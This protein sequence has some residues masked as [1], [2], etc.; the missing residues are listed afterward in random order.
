MSDLTSMSDPAWHTLNRQV[1]VKY[2][3]LI[4][5]PEGPAPSAPTMI[6][7]E[8]L[9]HD[10]ARKDAH[11][12]ADTAANRD[13]AG[14]AGGECECDCDGVD[15]GGDSDCNSEEDAEGS[16]EAAIKQAAAKPAAAK[17]MAQLPWWRV[18]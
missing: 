12:A 15:C 1:L 16:E 8:I 7:K 17:Q 11:T 14:G 10:A 9:E 3:T 13:G 4:I 6:R 18:E 2:V 5:N